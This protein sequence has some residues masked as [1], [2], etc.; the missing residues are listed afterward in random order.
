MTVG[1]AR[2]ALALLLLAAA[3][4]FAAQPETSAQ[5]PRAPAVVTSRDLSAGHKLAAADVRVVRLPTSAI[6]AGALSSPKD[7]VGRVLSGAARSGEPVTDARLVGHAG[8]ST[9]AAPGTATVPIR[10]ADPAVAALLQ[11]GALV[12]VVTMAESAGESRT[13]ASQATVVTVTADDNETRPDRAQ[14]VLLQLPT[15]TANRLAA[16]SLKQP[17]TVTLR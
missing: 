9:S 10:L 4:V 14:L 16:V 12:D 8:S 1:F 11:P 5:E 2:R 7:A 6:P 13:L 15:A 3:A 17:V